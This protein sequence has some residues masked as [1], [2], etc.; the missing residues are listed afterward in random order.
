MKVNDLQTALRAMAF[1][2][3]AWLP[4][5]PVLAQDSGDDIAE[6][7]AM[8]L[9][10]Q[11]E[12]TAL[13][14]EVAT[15][16][17]ADA[18]PVAALPPPAPAP[19]P[20]VAPVPAP[21][22]AGPQPVLSRYGISLYGFIKADAWTDDALLSHQEIPFWV[23]PDS[24]GADGG[25][26]MTAKET[27]LGADLKGPAVAGGK[28]SGKLELDFYANIAT[29]EAMDGKHAYTPRTRHAYAQWSDGDWT[30][31]AGKTWDPYI[32]QF[33]STVNFTYYSFQGQLGLRKT[34]V[35]VSRAF[36]IGDDSSL[37]LTAAAIDPTGRIH[38]GDMDGD[39]EDD[40]EDSG[41]PMWSAKAA[42]VAPMFGGKAEFAIAGVAGKEDMDLLDASYDVWAVQAGWKLPLGERLSWKLSAF[43]GTNL[44]SLWGGI[45]QG[46]N[47]GL[48][49]PIDATGGWT[50]LEWLASDSLTL[51][52]GYSIDD[53]E[54]ADLSPGSR[55]LNET[56]LI[57]GY[58][59]FDPSLVLGLEF[60]HGETGY[61]QSDGS[62][63]RAKNNRIQST[64]IFKF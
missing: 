42:A 2:T 20:V 34:Q 55:T 63:Q 54:D 62:T 37:T 15:L 46:I 12:V 57:N 48:H 53:P 10:L 35:R 16:R 21:A 64:V 44:D 39:K 41:M 23:R 26:G 6:L 51:H 24:A 17:D 8:V 58:Y 40:G 27:R 18:A 5:M 22:V 45:G 31:L 19:A 11:S 47:L 59:T 43:A 56:W 29:P 13:R 38:G 14:A 52:A 3:V 28:V 1:C 50:Q 61:L 49:T 32:V 33:P 30:V 25:F 4:A 9:A 60:L 7:R 36:G